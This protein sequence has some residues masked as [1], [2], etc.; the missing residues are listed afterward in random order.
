MEH[1]DEDALDD[2]ALLRLLP[3]ER[4]AA[5]EHLRSCPRC[6]EQA[7]TLRELVAALRQLVALNN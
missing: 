7:A 6:R 1:L 4:A 3:E 5:D 2:Y